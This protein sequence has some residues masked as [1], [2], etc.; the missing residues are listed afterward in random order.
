MSCTKHILNFEWDH[1]TW[2]KRVSLAET[3]ASLETSMWGQPVNRTFVRCHKHDV[4]E[5]CG[6]IRNDEGC[7]CDPAQAERCAIRLAWINDPHHSAE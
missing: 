7:L 2:R 6:K 5:A 1:H 3:V 4:C